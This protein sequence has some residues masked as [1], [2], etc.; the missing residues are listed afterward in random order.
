MTLCAECL[1]SSLR[2]ISGI[3]LHASG[4]LI[5]KPRVT[6]QSV[7]MALGKCSERT[8]RQQFYAILFYVVTHLHREIHD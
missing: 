7:T 1:V 3:E 4:F 2:N 5:L 6:S 8:T